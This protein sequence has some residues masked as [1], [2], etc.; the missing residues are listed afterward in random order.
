MGDSIFQDTMV[1]MTWP[2][3]EKAAGQGALVL[4]PTGVIEEHGPHLHVAVDIQTSHLLCR[5]VKR[6]LEEKGVSALIC[7]PFFWGINTA[8]GA[9]PGSFSVRRET[10]TAVL[11]DILASLR[12]WGFTRVY[13]I[14]WHGDSDHN[15]A[16]FDAF[17]QACDPVAFDAR[18]IVTPFELKRYRFSGD[19]PHLLVL[20]D[21]PPSAPRTPVVDLHA[22]SLET[23]IMAA[24]FPQDLDA[25]Q[26][27]QLAATTLTFA[28]LG[29]WTEDARKETPLGY[30]GNPAAFDAEAGRVFIERTA[31]A[32]AGLIEQTQK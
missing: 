5:N 8:T 25:G 14:N 32:L 9:F 17:A 1:E 7:P 13:N 21:A 24:Y 4:L 31:A 6:I 19:E 30:L 26:A 29:R 20:R 15:Q 3:I 16:L 22:G 23:G 10:M 12:R 11:V 18:C 28:D 27:R 2:E